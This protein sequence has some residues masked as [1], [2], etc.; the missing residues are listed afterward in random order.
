MKSVTDYIV[1]LKKKIIANLKIKNNLDFR[2]FWNTKWKKFTRN[3]KKHLDF[4]INI[5]H[6][7]F[8]YIHKHLNSLSSAFTPPDVQ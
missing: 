2:D 8:A 4:F 3:I 1:E 7:M 6:V 5:S